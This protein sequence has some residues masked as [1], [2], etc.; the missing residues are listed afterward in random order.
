MNS[1]KKGDAFFCFSWDHPCIQEQIEPLHKKGVECYVLPV[2]ADGSFD[3]EECSNF[4][5]SSRAQRKLLNYTFVHNETGVIWPISLAL[6]LKKRTGVLVHV[7]CAQYL[8]RLELDEHWD[9]GC[10]YYSFSGHKFGAMK[11]VGFSFIKE[12]F[13]YEPLLRGGAQQEDMRSGTLNH[14]GIYSLKLAF[15]DLVKIDHKKI[16]DLK[17]SLIIKLNQNS[18][19]RFSLVLDAEKMN[20]NTIFCYL[21]DIDSQLLFTKLSIEGFDVGLGSACSS[22]LVKE[23]TTLKALGLGHKSQQVLRLSIGWDSLQVSDQK[24]DQL[25][26]IIQD[27]CDK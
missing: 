25:L 27:I 23:N 11:G 2:L 24:W 10:D 21:E 26:L 16:R 18:S 7:D 5:S 14:L 19:G 13:P 9:T 20:T 22:G 8:G 1:L 3:M 17:E 4:I 12:E 6:E 15:L